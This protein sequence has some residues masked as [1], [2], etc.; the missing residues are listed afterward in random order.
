MLRHSA[1]LSRA[2]VEC[3]AQETVELAQSAG[4]LCVI[5]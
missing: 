1:A 5:D 2:A 3:S 4:Q